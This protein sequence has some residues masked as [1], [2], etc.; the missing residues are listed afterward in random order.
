ME[1]FLEAKGMEFFLE[2]KVIDFF[3]KDIEITTLW[4]I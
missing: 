2:A 1:F 3:Y 4:I